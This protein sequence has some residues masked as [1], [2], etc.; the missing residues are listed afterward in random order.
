MRPRQRAFT[1]I[2]L[3]L[4]LGWVGVLGLGLVLFTSVS[5][6]FVAR[7]LATNHSH[8]AT[9][10]S[11]QTLLTELNDSASS[12]RLLNFNGTTY[13]DVTP[14][15]SSEVDK[16]SGQFIG[17][18]ANGVRFRRMVGGPF[19]M[20]ANTTPASTT[21]SFNF[22]DGSGTFLPKAGDKVVLPL[23]SRE[24]DVT[25][26][27]GG[28]VTISPAVGFTL[29][30]D[31]P[32]LITGYFYRRAAFIVAGQELRYHEE[33]YGASQSTYRVVRGGITSPQPFSL[34]F[35]SVGALSSDSL[36][37]R[38]SMEITDLQYSA[39]RFGNGT[40][41]LYSIFPP[42]TQPTALTATN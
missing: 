29:N 18:R 13:N 1:L 23:I 34:L 25:A 39:R 2:E 3:L 11:S 8:E 6:R 37:L 14:T 20:T 31:S 32:N 5:S 41:T 22:T 19:A 24:F 30:V 4:T 33:F 35:P 10:I 28:T 36:N 7:N 21:L 9:R 40:T 15:G 16:L 42:R 12:F 26:V 17:T 27:G 38:V